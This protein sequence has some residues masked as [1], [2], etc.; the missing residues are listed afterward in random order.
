MSKNTTIDVET[1]NSLQALGGKEDEGEDEEESE[2]LA[3]YIREHVGIDED[4]MVAYML[5]TDMPRVTTKLAK[6][7][8]RNKRRLKEWWRKREAM[9]R[10]ES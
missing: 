10:K 3:T 6:R 8:Q 4:A 1:R 2:T 7:K 5:I 9:D